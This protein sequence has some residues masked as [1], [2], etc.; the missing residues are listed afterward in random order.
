VQHIG[1]EHRRSDRFAGKP[2]PAL[3]KLVRPLAW[4]VSR[5]HH[6]RLE[7][8]ARIPDGPAILVGNHGLLGYET[9]VFFERLLDARGRLPLGLADRWFFKVPLLR[10]AL[11]R[12]GGTYGS[13]INAHRALQRGD[14]VLCYP[15]GVRE[16]LKRRPE[17][18]YRCLWERSQG[19]AR[20]ALQAGVPIVP[21]AAAGVDDTF[22]VRGAIEGTGKM[23]MGQSKYDL[24][25][26]GSFIPRPVPLWFRFGD[27]IYPA[28]DVQELYRTV[29]SRTQEMLDDLVDEWRLACAS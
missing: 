15:G 6:S 10:D 1:L 29:W 24:P 27:P 23:L 4:L 3:V 28:N 7:G 21:F 26:L 8:A 19:F 2:S 12:L 9:I 11:V 16:V 20:V 18:K 13:A 25:V 22:E 14:W 17:D 5:F